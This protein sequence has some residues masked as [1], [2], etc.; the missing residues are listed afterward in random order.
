MNGRTRGTAIACLLALPGASLAQGSTLPIGSTASGAARPGC[1][2]VKI[3]LSVI[4]PVRTPVSSCL[5]T[6]S[7]FSVTAATRRYF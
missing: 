4:R 1:S 2:P 5:S 7:T 3:P 6:S